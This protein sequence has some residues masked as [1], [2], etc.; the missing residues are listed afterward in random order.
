MIH[1]RH[2]AVAAVV[3]ESLIGTYSPQEQVELSRATGDGRG[4]GNL[5]Q[6]TGLVM[7]YKETKK[8]NA[9][10]FRQEFGTG[11]LVNL[12]EAASKVSFSLWQSFVP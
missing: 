3:I 5:E 6:S 12:L 4:S 1:L 7:G 2:T 8:L 10:D 11:V 9:Y